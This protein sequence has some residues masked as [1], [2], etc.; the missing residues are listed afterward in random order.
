M[1]YLFRAKPRHVR[2]IRTD[3]QRRRPR[4]IRTR[5]P[6][7]FHAMKTQPAEPNANPL[8]DTTNSAP[9][10]PKPHVIT[11]RAVVGWVLYDLANTI[12]SM[13]VVSLFFSLWV[14][15]AV[16][17]QKADATYGVIAGISMAII[18][19][20][21]PLLGAMTDRAPRRMA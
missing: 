6:D 18:F 8:A 16:G 4:R 2:A 1:F 21:S 9:N 13:G 14:R 11:R 15:E 17:V 19:F 3:D 5:S 12:F 7:N 20:V 10:N